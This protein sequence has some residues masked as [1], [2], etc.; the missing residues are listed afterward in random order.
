MNCGE[1][2]GCAGEF[3]ITVSF[4]TGSGD[5]QLLLVNGLEVPMGGELRFQ[6][7][8][9]P[10]TPVERIDKLVL[11]V[12]SIGAPIELPYGVID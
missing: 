12:Q 9:D 8:Q 2:D 3:G 7:L 1:P 11:E 5:R 6:G 10:S 4:D